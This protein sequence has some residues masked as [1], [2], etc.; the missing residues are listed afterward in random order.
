MRALVAIRK[1]TPKDVL[2]DI[3]E[4]LERAGVKNALKKGVSTILKD[5]IS[6]HLPFLSQGQGSLQQNFLG[7]ELA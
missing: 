7:M 6:W 5:N 4:L 3:P 2:Q 1:T